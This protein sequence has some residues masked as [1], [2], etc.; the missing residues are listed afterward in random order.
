[1][2]ALCLVKAAEFPRSSRW[3]KSSLHLPDSE[4]GGQQ[5]CVHTADGHVAVV[6]FTRA[7]STGEHSDYIFHFALFPQIPLEAP[8]LPARPLRS[9]T[10]R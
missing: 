1:M 6:S 7:E 8:R 9:V 2:L 3:R 4:V 5:F 10:R